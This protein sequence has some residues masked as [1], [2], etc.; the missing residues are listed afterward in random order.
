MV[1]SFALICVDNIQIQFLFLCP[2][3]P[4]NDPGVST[5]AEPRIW[6]SRAVRE[7]GIYSSAFFFCI[8]DTDPAANFS[9]RGNLGEGGEG[10]A[11]RPDI[12]GLREAVIKGE[13]VVT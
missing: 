12:L 5:C 4:S 10:G 2:V 3:K 11:R 13:V 7:T 8:S 6:I 9:W 1:Y